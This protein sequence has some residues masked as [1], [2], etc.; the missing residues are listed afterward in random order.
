MIGLIYKKVSDLNGVS[1]LKGITLS[2]LKK[3]FE[4]LIIDD[5]E[6]S[7]LDALRKHEYNITQKR[8]L[9]DLKDAEAYQ[10]ILC[11]IRGVGKFLETEYDG[12]YLIKQL[13]MKY[14]D[15][16]IIA[17]T[18]TPYDP[19]FEKFL[20]Y[21]IK[22]VPKGTYG[23]DDWTALLDQLLNDVIDPVKIWEKTR[24]Q[25][26]EAGV[27]TIDVA[28]YESKFVSAVKKGKLEKWQKSCE[29]KSGEGIQIVL[30]MLKAIAAVA[31][32][33]IS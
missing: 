22:T 16:T 5:E 30:A 10:I 33:F 17:Y 31:G 15:K 1:V 7:F 3:K 8:D 29:S 18:A 20:G 2:E 24:R 25:L 32:L 4:I 28:K 21:A 19:S 14:P 11:D 6:F 13:K 9:T 23:L 27:S 26:L 12:A